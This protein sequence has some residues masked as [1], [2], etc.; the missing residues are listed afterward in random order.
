MIYIAECFGR[1]DLMNHL[2][3]ELELIN[4]GVEI[5]QEVVFN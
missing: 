4:R 3:I 5:N 1:G 2:G